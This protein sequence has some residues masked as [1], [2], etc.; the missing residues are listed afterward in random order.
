MK[1][2]IRDERGSLE[3]EPGWALYRQPDG[4]L[5]K[6][7]LAKITEQM[8]DAAQD[9]EDLYKRG[10]PNTWG[11]VF[12]RMLAHADRAPTP[13]DPLQME[14]RLRWV[15]E[16]AELT[17]SARGANYWALKNLVFDAAGDVGAL[18][19][20]DRFQEIMAAIDVE[21]SQAEPDSSPSNSL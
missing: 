14:R 1:S 21:L 15:I 10:T 12:R 4:S 2:P 19:L 18:R 9:V 3:L 7:N 13:E 16:Q 17:S 8:L 11:S 6:I 5:A 20:D